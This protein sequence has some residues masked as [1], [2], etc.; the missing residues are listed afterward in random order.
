MSAQPRRP[1]SEEEQR[2]PDSLITTKMGLGHIFEL[3][4]Q[5]LLKTGVPHKFS[6]SSVPPDSNSFLGRKDTVRS[7]SPGHVVRLTINSSF[8]TISLGLYMLMHIKLP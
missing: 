5:L 8:L 2:F 1:E 7:S 6:E 4:K 3:Y